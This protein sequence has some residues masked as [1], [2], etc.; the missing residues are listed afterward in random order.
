VGWAPGHRATVRHGSAPVRTPAANAG[1][2]PARSSDDFPL[3]EGPTTVTRLASDTRATS[4]ATRR[5][6]PKK[7][8]ASEASNRARPL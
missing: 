5:S 6:R 1:S 4:S 2:R 8:S 7:L 3:P